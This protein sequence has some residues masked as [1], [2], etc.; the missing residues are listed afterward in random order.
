MSIVYKIYIVLLLIRDRVKNTLDN[1]FATKFTRETVLLII[2]RF[3]L[4]YRVI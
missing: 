4:T 1:L 3:L 2:Y